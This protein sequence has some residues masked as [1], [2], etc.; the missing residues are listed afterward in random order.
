MKKI[1]IIFT[2]IFFLILSTGII[3]QGPPPPP[4][5]HGT[6]QDQSAGGTAPLSGGIIIL[7][8]LGTVYGSKKVYDTWKTEN[9]D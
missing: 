2:G 5:D 9:I 1:K 4:A 8:T 3:A 6:D 7:L